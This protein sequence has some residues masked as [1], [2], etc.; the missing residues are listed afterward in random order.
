M[1]SGI[2][3]HLYQDIAISSNTKFW[4]RYLQLKLTN[5]LLTLTVAETDTETDKFGFHS[6][7]QKVH[8]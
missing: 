6:N 4:M 2:V 7:V 1:I 8:T 3:S 5:G